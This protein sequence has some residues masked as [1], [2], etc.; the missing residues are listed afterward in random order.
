MTNRLFDSDDYV[1]VEY[2]PENG[3]WTHG[4]DLQA[5]TAASVLAVAADPCSSYLSEQVAGT[6]NASPKVYTVHAFAANVSARRNLRCANGEEYEMVLALLAN[7]GAV[8]AAEYALWNGI[9][10]WDA[11]VQPSLHNNDVQTASVGA[12]VAETLANVVT[13]YSA[14]TALQFY[15]IHLGVKSALDLSAL[16]YAYTTDPASGT[17]RLRAVDMPIVV[18]PYYPPAGV[19]LTGPIKINVGPADAFQV[20]DVDLNRTN[21][22]GFQMLSLAFDPSTAVRAA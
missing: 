13:A 8:S 4:F 9:G 6:P 7:G 11:N 16:G 15:V 21:I 12:N 5:A 18:S 17:L 1:D 14:L 19:A 20:Y 22:S 10:G 2:Q 3:T